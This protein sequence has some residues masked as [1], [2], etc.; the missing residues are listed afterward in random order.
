MLLLL[1]PTFICRHF[2]YTFWISFF[3]TL[4]YSCC[5]CSYSFFFFH[6]GK[7]YNRVCVIL[8][9]LFIYTSFFFLY[10]ECV[11]L[12]ENRCT[13]PDLDQTCR[14]TFILEKFCC[15]VLTIYEFPVDSWLIDSSGF[16]LDEVPEDAEAPAAA[17]PPAPPAA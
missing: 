17:A 15:S 7:S 10:I 8:F 14:T 2:I 3:L 16:A 1:M 6:R 12:V 5:S 9:F 13:E 11:C 4:Q